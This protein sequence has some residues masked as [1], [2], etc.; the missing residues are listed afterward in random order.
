MQEMN[1]IS[2]KNI[3]IA[4]ADSLFILKEDTKMFFFFDYLLFSRK[5]CSSIL[6]QILI[7]VGVISKKK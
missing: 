5:N 7:I 2:H 1:K 3:A 6:L 4:D